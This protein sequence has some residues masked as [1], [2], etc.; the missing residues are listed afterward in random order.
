M[1]DNISKIFRLSCFPSCKLES[2]KQI[3]FLISLLLN[4]EVK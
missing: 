4:F 2:L 1:F 3:E